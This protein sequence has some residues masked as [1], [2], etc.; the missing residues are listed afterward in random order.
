MDTDA[1]K[2]ASK[3]IDLRIRDI[4]SSR[5][6]FVFLVTPGRDPGSTWTAG[7]SLG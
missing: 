5:V 3:A 6:I 7:P 2:A 4:R 1:M